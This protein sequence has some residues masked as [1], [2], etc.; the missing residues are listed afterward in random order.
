[1]SY[2]ADPEPLVAQFDECLKAI[3]ASGAGPL[4]D[5]HAKRQ[6][7]S[8]LDPD[9]Y[10]E[11][12][13]PL[14]LDTE[15][16][17]FSIEE[18][19][20]HVCE[21][22]WC[23]HPE[24]PTTAVRPKSLPLSAAYA[25]KDVPDTDLLS[26]FDRVLREAFDLLDVLRDSVKDPVPG[27]VEPPP[28]PPRQKAGGVRF[29]PTKW[30]DTQNRSGGK[31]H[32]RN[33]FRHPPHGSRFAAPP[34]PK[35]GN[36]SQKHYT[37][38]AARCI[39]FHSLS[40]A[41]I[42][43]C[44]LCPGHYH[45]TARCPAVAGA[46]GSDAAAAAHEMDDVVAAFQTAFDSED[47]AAF[48]ELCTVH[49]S[50]VVR[51]DV[52]PF[53]YPAS[54]DLGLRAQYAGLAVPAPSDPGMTARLS[55]ARAV[56]SGLRDATAAAR[57]AAADGVSFGTISVPQVV[58]LSPPANPPAA[59][60]HAAAVESVP[61][62]PPGSAPAPLAADDPD[63]FNSPFSGTFADR[64]ALRIEQDPNLHFGS[65]SLPPPPAIW[66]P[67]L[68][69]VGSDT[70]S[71]CEPEP[72]TAPDPP[73]APA[74]NRIGVPPAPRFARLAAGLL[75]V[76]TVLSCTT[77]AHGS[78]VQQSVP[79]PAMPPA[80]HSDWVTANIYTVPPE[81]SPPALP[82][83][84]PA[85]LPVP[86]PIPNPCAIPPGCYSGLWFP[87]VWISGLWFWTS[88][89]WYWFWPSGSGSGFWLVGYLI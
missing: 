33:N 73:A 38:H 14:R 70:D 69:V 77:T 17:K 24:G 43:E 57:A 62:L 37:K 78:V 79:T 34:F 13:A 27:P 72:F 59:V 32:G 51:S 31:F 44:P 35:G 88:G 25:S 65:F 8:A 86:A 16:A 20:A 58:P 39:S 48:A 36:W 26:E 68:S 21:V 56:L 12:I 81:L 19:F 63:N 42:Q 22:W 3:A 55:E 54:L 66:G 45:D 67:P 49:D 15:L 80:V 28:P 6:L 83:D 52:D 50:P 47:D 53:T 4:D 60:P 75:S 30:R 87:G 71:E 18:I 5:Q 23:A 64:F 41:F 82:P 40:S 7:L 1:M 2:A 61:S 10:K 29:P 76:L 85:Y 11:V 9:F 84:P 46:C 89:F 74:A